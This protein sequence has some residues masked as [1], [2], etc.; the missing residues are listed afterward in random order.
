MYD[1]WYW[2]ILLFRYAANSFLGY[3]FA[4]GFLQPKLKGRA[5]SVM[6]V[7]SL[8]V[9]QLASYF[10]FV[11]F[12]RNRFDIF[13]Y[14]LVY[15]LGLILILRLFFK[16]SWN[17]ILFC[18]F[19]VCGGRELMVSILHVFD[20]CFMLTL[21]DMAVVLFEESCPEYYAAYREQIF[22]W[23]DIADSILAV[24]VYI[25]IYNIY[26]RLIKKSFENKTAAFSRYENML[27]IL[28]FISSVCISVMIKMMNQYV[29]T[30]YGEFFEKVSG[31][32]Y[33]VIMEEYFLSSFWIL[34]SDIC[35]M[36]TNVAYIKI[37]QR[38]ADY[39]S[40]KEKTRMLE[41]QVRETEKEVKEIQDIYAD[42][43]GLRHDMK[44]NLE[45]ISLYIQRK[46]G[47]DKELSDYLGTMTETVNRLDFSHNTGNGITDIIL[48]QKTAEAAKR[49][50]ALTHSFAFPTK[51]T[52]DA[53]HVG[54]IL[55]N[56]LQNSIEACEN[57]QE[58]EIYL[59]SYSKGSLYFIKCQNSFTGRLDFD[60]NSGLPLTEKENKSVHGIGLSNIKRC[61]E[62]Y[63][64]DIDIA[65]ENGK[66]TLTVMLHT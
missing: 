51:K 1:L 7:F 11:F 10:P 49:G 15:L 66:F 37:F 59:C 43:R 31:G 41:N 44:N 28:P 25:L 52:I 58:K 65:A 13:F 45:S 54:I 35:L 55:N 30:T 47:D 22:M 6:C 29:S 46:Y 5:A 36:L 62:K 26:L 38:L 60:K 64:G 17:R 56:A 23:F 50:I 24:T 2:F 3:Y 40:E 9:I 32:E 61:A 8:T 20:Y 14:I 39:N 57:E 4:K 21:W 42:I 16:G 63:R 53:Y 34:M 12:Y 27:L 48:A 33:F 19:A 18:A